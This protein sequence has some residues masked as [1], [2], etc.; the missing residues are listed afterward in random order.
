[1]QVAE[2]QNSYR[3]VALKR[4]F[5][6]VAFCLKVIP[7]AVYGRTRV[8]CKH[9]FEKTGVPRREQRVTRAEACVES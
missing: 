8:T 9:A 4:Y 7:T 5:F 3:L 2:P 6:S 1:M